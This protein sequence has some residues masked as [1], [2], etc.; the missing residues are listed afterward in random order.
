M[1]DKNIT[2]TDAQRQVDERAPTDISKRLREYASNPGYSHNDYADTMRAAAE[3][4]ERYYGGM[5]A[6]KQ[7]AEK[8]D[9]DW[10]AERMG[11]VNDRI[12]AGQSQ[13]IRAQVVPMIEQQVADLLFEGDVVTEFGHRALINGDAIY[14]RL[15]LLTSLANKIL[16]AAHQVP[17]A[18][19]V[20]QKAA[21]DPD[22]ERYRW[23]AG[24]WTIEEL[25]EAAAKGEQPAEKPQLA[26][27]N[28]LALW[29]LSKGQVDHAIDTAMFCTNTDGGSDA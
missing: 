3:E 27:I 11:R 10:N 2:L 26:V 14:A 1:T 7:T 9:R 18:Q 19:E 24:G 6:W 17:V 15:D 12:S 29:Y 8:K 21:P 4:I 20:T 25:A 28:H 22:G 5:L 23:L 13:A 16:A